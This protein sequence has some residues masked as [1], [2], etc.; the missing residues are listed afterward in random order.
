VAELI[1]R[2]EV[3]SCLQKNFHP[4]VLRCIWVP[5]RPFPGPSMYLRTTVNVGASCQ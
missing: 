2:V 5:R 1:E 4:V 3:D